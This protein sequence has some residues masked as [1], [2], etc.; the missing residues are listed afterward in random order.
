M[1][2][3]DGREFFQKMIYVTLIFLSVKFI[4]DD[5]FYKMIFYFMVEIIVDSFKYS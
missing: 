4:A 3:S 5:F 2:L 1:A